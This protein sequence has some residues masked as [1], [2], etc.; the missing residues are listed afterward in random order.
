MEK[1]ER[2]YQEALRTGK[3]RFCGG[4]AIAGC[5]GSIPLLG[6][7]YQFWCEECQKDLTEYSKVA[8]AKA[9]ESLPEFSV[10]EAGQKRTDTWLAE[11]ERELNEYMQAKIKRRRP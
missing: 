10:T 1:W 3:C 2:R 9:E 5:G 6:E 8:K 7:H 11:K 4:Q